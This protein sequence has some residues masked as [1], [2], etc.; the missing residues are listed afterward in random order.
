MIKLLKAIVVWLEARFPEKVLLTFKEFNELHEELGALN[1]AYQG[2][3]QELGALK[4]VVADVQKVKDEVS[5]LHVIMG[6]SGR[7]ASP[8]ER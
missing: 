5:K 8:L 6:F 7:G 3:N 1:K 4:G 2:L